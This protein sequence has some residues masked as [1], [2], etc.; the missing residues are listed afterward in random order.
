MGRSGETL[1]RSILGVV[2]H[3]DPKGIRHGGIHWEVRRV[4]GLLVSRGFESK[5]LGLMKRVRGE[6]NKVRVFLP[7]VHALNAFWGSVDYSGT[8]TMYGK[9]LQPTT[10]SFL[11]RNVCSVCD[12]SRLRCMYVRIFSF[13]FFFLF[14]LSSYRALPLPEATNM[15]SPSMSL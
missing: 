12:V 9:D 15:R 8:G 14:F 6:K 2:V 11:R 7:T 5:H 4:R 3:P 10:I 13:L 1:T